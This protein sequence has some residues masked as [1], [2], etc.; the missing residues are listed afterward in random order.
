MLRSLTR[1]S[2]LIYT[3]LGVVHALLL[4]YAS[5]PIALYFS[6]GVS[7]VD[8]VC[9]LI[10]A[11]V[12]IVATYFEKKR[13]NGNFIILLLRAIAIITVISFAFS[14]VCLFLTPFLEEM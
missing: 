12:A 8:S 2:L 14:A 9:S 7:C 3:A 6:V 4:I 1:K 10:I 13:Y 11:A 5:L